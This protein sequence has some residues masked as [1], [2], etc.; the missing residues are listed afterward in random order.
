MLSLLLALAMLFSMIPAAFA[1]ESKETVHVVVE[2]T[3][4]TEEMNGK[5]P[6]WTGE[7][8]NTDVE[9]SADSTMMTCIVAAL[10]TVDTAPTIV[11][12]E[13]GRYITEVGGIAER[14]A[15]DG[16]GWMGTLNDWFGSATFDEVTVANGSLTAGDEIRVMY[17][18]DF[19]ADLGSD[20]NSTD[21]TVKAV[22]FSAGSLD[23][24]FAADTHE[25]TLSVPEGTESVV[26]TPTAA[27]RNYQVHTYVGE[28]EYKRTASVPV[29][30]GTVITVK[31]GDPAWP[32]MNDNTGDA[33]VYTFTVAQEVPHTPITANVT[34]S[35]ASAFVK[36][37]NGADTVNMQVQLD[38]KLEY[39]VNDIL[40]AAH[41]Q[42]CADGEDGFATATCDY[43]EYITKLWGVETSNVGYYLNGAMAYALTD[44]V[45]NGDFLDVFIYANDY[46]DTEAYAAF[47]KATV[48]TDDETSFELTLKSAVFDESYNMSMVPCEGATITVDGVKTSAVTDAEG[49]ATVKITTVGTHVV[50]AMKTKTV[51]EGDAAKEISAITAPACVATVAAAE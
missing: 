13:Y 37:K 12:S 29:T 23:K 10:A 47:D 27:N 51:G 22:A 16:S 11:E 7:L 39:T 2:N 49:K 9:L 43:G 33:Q 38:T 4:F 19:G 28:T 17:T 50:S 35:N 18:C 42:F 36:D 40:T 8:V 44:K 25:Y 34:F 20:Y 26:V 5:T 14:D 24:A 32:S 6:A 15:A 41:E 3:T 48:D 46:P 30:A 45:Q 21:K 31:C 1:E